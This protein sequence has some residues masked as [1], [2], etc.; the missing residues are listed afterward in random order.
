MTTR[1]LSRLMGCILA[2]LVVGTVSA[3]AVPADAAGTVE[4]R[5]AQLSATASCAQGDVEIEY[6]A[7]GVER[8]LASFTAEGGA[9]LH[10]YDVAVYSPT[11]NGVEYILSQTSSPPPPGTIVAVHVTIG[12]SPADAATGEFFL[13]YRCDSRTNE[14]GGDNELLYVC[15]GSYGTCETTADEY[16]TLGTGPTPLVPKFTG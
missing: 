7:D 11:H 6:T 12:S 9:T 10:T 15:I 14:E 4:A 5:G 2:V 1:S 13:A 8:Q 3:L 16:L